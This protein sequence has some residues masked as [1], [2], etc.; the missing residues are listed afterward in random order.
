MKYDKNKNMNSFN[1]VA[2]ILKLLWKASPFR[3][4][5]T[6]FRI[7]SEQV[8][9]VFFFVY[10]TQYIFTAIETKEKYSNLLIMIGFACMCH[11]GIHILSA[12]YTYYTLEMTLKFISTYLL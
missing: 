7:I 12:W 2:Y 8:F 5:A 6:L 9:Y 10:L 3:I 1:N 4:F 11:I